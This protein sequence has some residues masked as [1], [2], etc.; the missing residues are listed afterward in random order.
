MASYQCSRCSE[1]LS[2]PSVDTCPHCDY[3]PGEAYLDR[4][5][6]QQAVAI[7]CFISILLSP[8]GLY[9]L[10]KGHQNAK[11]AKSATPAEKVDHTEN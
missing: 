2:D 8:I 10:Y 1:G 3:N 5:F 11:K 4:R 6:V 9:L 7:G